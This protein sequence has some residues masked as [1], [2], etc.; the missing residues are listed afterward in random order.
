MGEAKYVDVDG[1]KTRYFEAGTGEPMVLVHGG[2]YGSAASSAIGWMPIFPSLAGHFH[3]YSVDKLGMG[4]TDLPGS[5]S[6]YTMQATTRHLYRFME[7]LGLEKVH[8]VGH[9]RG[10]LPAARIAMDHP[11]MIQTLTLFD[12]NTLAPGDPAP[13]APN[14]RPEG[15]PPTQD[16]LRRELLA[17]RNVVQ[18]DFITD[19][20]VEAQLAVA[21]NP[22]I[23]KAGEKLE[24]LRKR[25]IEFNP[26]KV[27]TR[28]ALARNSGTG[29]WLYKTKDETLE[30]L[31]AG[32]LKTP[33]NIIWGYND[34]SA[35]YDMGVDLFRL[36]SMSVD[37]AQLHFINQCGHAP[38]RE[39]PQEVTDL[40]V[41]FIG[42]V[43]D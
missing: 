40:M 27:R 43:N 37:Q 41:H 10:G 8:L 19:E 42:S 32:R 2:H 30:M 38:Y 9:S 14:L 16:S 20:Y 4:F 21:L 39:Y 13:S 6:D 7:T 29:W 11:E 3:V 34:R 15:P 28:P 12:S 36:I 18:K 33:T 5:D 17:G 25:F 35:T 1:I 22:S 23:R 24:T 31:Q 26:E